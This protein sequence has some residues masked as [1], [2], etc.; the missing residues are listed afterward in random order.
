MALGELEVKPQQKVGEGPEFQV[1]SVRQTA[2]QVVSCEPSPPYLLGKAP[3]VHPKLIFQ[4][5]G[6]TQ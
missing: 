6:D 4:V 3:D 2:L 1:Q 5:L